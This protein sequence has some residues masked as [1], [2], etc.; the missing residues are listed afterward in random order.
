VLSCFL[1]ELDGVVAA[2][3]NTEPLVVIGT[4]T[5]RA[6][7][8]RAILRPGRLDLQVELRLPNA[9]ER[10]AVLSARA[11]ELPLSEALSNNRAATLASVAAAAVG[12]S[13]SDLVNVWREAAMLALRE[14][15]H[16]NAVQ[17]NHLARSVELLRAR[18]NR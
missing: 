1:T 12:A 11:D 18:L 6:Q 17:I 7:L 4:T 2:S 13:Y 5:H 14:D 15:V 9:Q 8:D 16:S 3:A 10:L